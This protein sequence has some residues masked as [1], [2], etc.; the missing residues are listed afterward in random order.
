MTTFKDFKTV[1]RSA[2]DYALLGLIVLVIVF[3]LSGLLGQAGKLAGFAALLTY[4]VEMP[5]SL[6]QRGG[7]ML[8]F[9][10]FGFMQILLVALI[11]NSGLP[12]LILLFAVSFACSWMMGYGARAALVGFISNV[13]ITIMPT[14]GVTNDLVASL[15]GF[16]AGSLLVIVASVIPP[17]LRG[18]EQTTEDQDEAL[19]FGPRTCNTSTLFGYSLIRAGQSP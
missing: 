1:E 3:G 7:G 4:M 10:V 2:L 12:L 19:V 17:L 14:M 6:R 16:S 15:I 5:G 9:A 18:A 8:V 11:G 13:W